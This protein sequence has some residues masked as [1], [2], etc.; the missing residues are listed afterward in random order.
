MLRI[1]MVGLGYLAFGLGCIGVF[2]PV[3]PTTPLLL[4]AT[5]LFARFSPRM[6][7]RIIATK[8]YRSYVAPFKD[9]GGLPLSAKVR[10][11]VISYTVLAISAYASQKVHVW[12]ILA[13]VALFLAWLLTFRIPTI[14]AEEAKAA[15]AAANGSGNEATAVQ[16]VERF[17]TESPETDAVAVA[18]AAAATVDV[19]A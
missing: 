4:L 12:I 10:I 3:L 14:S 16:G 1:F 15:R 11:L 9:A 17:N 6:H 5:F 13:C 8:V 7:D 19:R 2:V 18:A